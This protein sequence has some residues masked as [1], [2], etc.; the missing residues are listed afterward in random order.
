MAKKK[1]GKRQIQK[2]LSEAAVDPNAANQPFTVIANMRN[3]DYYEI[4]CIECVQEAQI[5]EPEQR[6]QRML[7]AISLLALAIAERDID[8]TVQASGK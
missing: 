7:T 8:A 2:I 6:R 4:R 5:M 1:P 3:P